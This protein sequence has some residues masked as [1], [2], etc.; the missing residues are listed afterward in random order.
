MSHRWRWA[1]WGKRRYPVWIWRRSQP[2]TTPHTPLLQ[3]LS[4]VSTLLSI[5]STTDSLCP[6]TVQTKIHKNY[7]LLSSFITIIIK[8]CNYWITINI[9]HKEQ[10]TLVIHQC[11]AP[12]PTKLDTVVL[13]IFKQYV[14]RLADLQRH[15]KQFSENKNAYRIDSFFKHE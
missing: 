13:H 9:C 6:V 4:Q 1:R 14:T 8:F 3:Y 12:I 5:T 15:K 10:I 11:Y 2:G 7:L